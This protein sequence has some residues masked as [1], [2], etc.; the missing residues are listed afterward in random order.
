MGVPQ[1][2]LKI[3]GMSNPKINSF[4][5][6]Q[7]FIGFD[8]ESQ[9]GGIFFRKFIFSPIFR[10]TTLLRLNEYLFNTKSPLILRLIPYLWYRRLGVKLGFSIP[11]N[12]FDYGLGIVHYGL[13]VI[14]P[15]AKIGKNCRIHAGVNIGG[16]AGFKQKGDNKSYAPI[17]GDNCYIG[18]G[19][20]LFGPIVIGDKTVIGANAVVTKSFNGNCTIAG[21]PAKLLSSKNSDGL[22]YKL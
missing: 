11:L 16:S 18:P 9:G 6:L 3:T 10:F 21:V 2:S 4:S 17:I 5:L 19:A 13:V 15:D 12:V 14:S 8:K 1:N 7:K 20:K 22:V